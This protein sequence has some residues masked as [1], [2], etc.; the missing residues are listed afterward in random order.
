[1]RPPWLRVLDGASLLAF[2]L[3]SSAAAL[4]LGPLP[5]AAHAPWILVGA[6]AGVAA[7]DLATGFVH[8]L[9][10][11]CFDADTPWIGR[12]VIQPFREHHVDPL[13]IT[14]HGFVEVT[15]NNALAL[16][17][18]VALGAWLAP[19]FGTSGLASGGL[20][21]LGTLALAAL[22]SNPIHRWAHL[23]RVPAP[24][25]WLQRYHLLLPPR[26]HARH[27]RGAH[28]THFC[29]VTG[30]MNPLV[31]RLGLFRALEPRRR[32]EHR[33]AGVGRV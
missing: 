17:P 9:G 4:R 32:H 22:F 1:M 27:H 29:V 14:R 33:E 12:A 8:W 26:H 31:D 11:R 15:G 20:G 25:A 6:L 13:G 23:P 5:G 18:V 16:L 30:W 28:A 19:A 3:L 2:A 7:A 10:D 24:L 21:A